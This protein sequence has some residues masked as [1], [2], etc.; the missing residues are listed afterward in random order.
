MPQ[1]L[2]WRHIGHVAAS[3]PMTSAVLDAQTSSGIIKAERH[4]DGR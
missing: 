4:F 2:R 1:Q 3:L